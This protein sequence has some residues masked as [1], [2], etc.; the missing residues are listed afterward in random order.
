VR[1][2]TFPPSRAAILV[3]VLAT[4][5]AGLAFGTPPA[6]A[7][8]R[9]GGAS[10]PSTPG[11]S[12]Q[13]WR[14][15]ERRVAKLTRHLLAAVASPEPPPPAPAPAPRSEEARRAREQEV[16]QELLDAAL[17]YGHGMG[18]PAGSDPERRQAEDAK[19]TEAIGKL[20]GLIDDHP[21]GLHPIRRPALEAVEAAER[22]ALIT[23]AFGP[24]GA[25]DRELVE[26]E[27][28]LERA[29][30]RVARR[31]LL[32][33]LQS[34]QLVIGADRP[35]IEALLAAGRKA[36]Q[37]AGDQAKQPTDEIRVETRRWV[38]GIE[39]EAAWQRLLEET[40]DQVAVNGR[41]A[42]EIA[43][44]RARVLVEVLSELLDRP[45]LPDSLRARVEEELAAARHDLAAAPDPPEQGGGTGGEPGQ[46]TE[47]PE[48]A[49]RQRAVGA[50][51][52]A[53]AVT[54]Q[55]PARPPAPADTEQPAR[56]GSS[57]AVAPARDTPTTPATE[58]PTAAWPPAAR[59]LPQPVRV[60]GATAAPGAEQTPPQRPT[61]EWSLTGAG[62]ATTPATRQEREGSKGSAAATPEQRDLLSL[63][64]S[65][66]WLD[67]PAVDVPE[68]VTPPVLVPRIPGAPTG[69]P[70]WALPGI[71]HGEPDWSLGF[72]GG[73][74]TP[75]GTFGDLR[76]PFVDQPS[77]DP[78]DRLDC[79]ACMLGG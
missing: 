75:G 3:V 5:T 50:T 53:P 55:P 44:D 47:E 74:G 13:L 30:L 36:D 9:P 21:G 8:S 1:P 71:G 52:E 46:A 42:A 15:A 51:P 24:E 34:G 29:R 78:L 4:V 61:P 67:V 18:E 79:A 10:R 31:K 28:R 64:P 73:F 63:E 65:P 38:A 48:E 62:P 26:A 56:T 66:A 70:G 69:W 2:S 32:D 33:Q 57:R 19:L 39:L 6:A 59:K 60:P 58:P 25:D 16:F 37:A 14:S 17:E 7:G 43:A 23:A 11:G 72:D 76:G 54:P 27:L 68:V 22:I 12:R 40:L 20:Q 41:P 77:G 45:D 49:A 35:A